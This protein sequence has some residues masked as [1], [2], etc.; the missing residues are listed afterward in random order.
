MAT[1]VDKVHDFSVRI[2]ASLLID[3]HTTDQR[4]RGRDG[5]DPKEQGYEL[6]L[7]SIEG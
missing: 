3:S 1:T 6:S 7:R 2:Q 4:H 5:Q